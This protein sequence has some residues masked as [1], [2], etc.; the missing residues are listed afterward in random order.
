MSEA[1][2][3]KKAGLKL[4]KNSGRGMKKGDFLWRHFIGDIKEG[5]SLTFNES[6]WGK[7]CSDTYTYGIGH[8]PMI[9][10]VL[11][12]GQMIACIELS[13]LKALYDEIDEL[14]KEHN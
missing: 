7:I 10:R 2:V 3:A 8:A 12:K 9:L 1:E 13:E 6:V 5:K 14:R 4:V 11:P